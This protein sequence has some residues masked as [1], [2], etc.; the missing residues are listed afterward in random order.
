M[1]AM[2]RFLALTCMTLGLLAGCAGSSAPAPDNSQA[3]IPRLLPGE[4]VNIQ[5]YG[6]G[7]LSGQQMVDDNGNI[8]VLLIGRVKVAG[9]TPREVEDK[10]KTELGN[11][12]VVNPSVSVA[13]THY[14]PVSVVG[15]VSKPGAFDWRSDMRVID[16]VALAGGYT[17]R[18]KTGGL[19]VMRQSDP[20]RAPVE[21]DGV[22]RVEPGD[23]VVVPER[24][25]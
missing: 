22:S 17:Y 14:L 6:Q 1:M 21:V 9:M 12:L 7:Q 16:A 8:S 3:S 13:V 24:W 18:A 10:L 15:E 11:G 20:S 4:I 5:V 19:E 25:F 2:F 23:V